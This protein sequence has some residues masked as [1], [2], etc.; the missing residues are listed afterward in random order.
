M[1]Y[2]TQLSPTD[3]RGLQ[4]LTQ[5]SQP[6]VAF[7][8]RLILSSATGLAVPDIARLFGCC[9][10]TVRLWIHRFATAGIRSLLP[11]ERISATIPPPTS[12]M[13]PPQS[14]VGGRTVKAIPLTVPE[15][16]RLWNRLTPQPPVAAAFVLHWSAYRRYKQALAML[17]HHRKRA[18]P[19]PVL[20]QVRL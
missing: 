9:R 3:Q 8:A 1:L 18:A 12:A 2:V 11:S 17:A 16:R 14:D 4:R 19:P 7:H 6:R 10:R 5:G 15:I 13:S 20:V